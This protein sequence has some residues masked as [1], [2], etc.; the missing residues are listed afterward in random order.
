M[1]VH[2]FHKVRLFTGKQSIVLLQSDKLNDRFEGSYSRANI[3]LR[4]A[5]YEGMREK[6]LQSLS[7]QSTFKRLTQCFS[8]ES[9]RTVLIGKVNYI[10]YNTDWLPEGNLFYPFLF[11]R[12]SFE[13][14]RELRAIIM[15]NPLS[16]EGELDL[17][18][19]VVYIV[20]YIDVNLHKLIE[21]VFFT[22]T[23]PDWFLSLVKF[24]MKR[25]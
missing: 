22:P 24:I 21:S 9:E 16:R 13:H 12:K 14:E 20:E 1:A 18:K 7:V 5:I 6:E 17:D 3:K 25:Y 8:P 15:I 19:E 2:G 10:D 23:A 4:P 11:K